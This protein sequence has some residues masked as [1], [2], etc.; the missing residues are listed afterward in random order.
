MKGRMI[1]SRRDQHLQQK[2]WEG[3][4]LITNRKRLKLIIARIFMHKLIVLLLLPTWPNILQSI[5]SSLFLLASA[6]LSLYLAL[7]SNFPF[8]SFLDSIIPFSYAGVYLYCSLAPFFLLLTVAVFPFLCIEVFTVRFIIYWTLL[9]LFL[10]HL[11][12]LFMYRDSFAISF[13]LVSLCFCFLLCFEIVL[14]LLSKTVASLN[15]YAAHKLI[16]LLRICILRMRNLNGRPNLT[17]EDGNHSLPLYLYHI[18]PTTLLLSRTSIY[19]LF[20]L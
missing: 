13:A 19:S 10:L 5:A 20:S 1:E 8:Y 14:E 3:P 6:F 15:P 16:Q 17:V 7:P 9:F 2:Y 12:S 11:L 18:A 4:L